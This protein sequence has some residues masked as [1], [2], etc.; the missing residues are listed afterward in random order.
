MSDKQHLAGSHGEHVLQQKYGTKRRAEPFYER[1]MLD[2]LNEPMRRFIERQEMF[3]IATADARGECDCSFRAGLPG[4]VR[5]LDRKTIVYPEYR[6]NGV[7]ASLGNIS[8]NPHIGIMFIDFLADTIGLHV[9][10]TASIVENEQLA[11]R[12]DIPDELRKDM[13]VEGGRKPERWVMVEV[14]EAYIHCSK[15][16]PLLAKCDKAIAWG[17]DD[18]RLKGGDFFE[19]AGRKGRQR[20][21]RPDPAMKL[22]ESTQ[23]TSS[24]HHE[25]PM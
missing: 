14:R 9:N 11:Q 2:Y 7:L 4:L 15:H 3:F 17:T 8:E 19:A 10:G 25:R 5:V 24:T 20:E 13:A 12:A 16:I 22:Q 18:A 6:G 23:Q 21:D 1:Q